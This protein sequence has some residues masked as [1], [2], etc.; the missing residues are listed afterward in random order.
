MNF[1]KMKVSSRLGLGFG[2]V[3]L[4]L[5]IVAA[6][7]LVRLSG[8]N[9][10]VEKLALERVPKLITVQAWSESLLQTSRLMREVLILDDEKQIRQAI[11]QSRE[12]MVKRQ[13]AYEN[14][15]KQAISA[16]EKELFAVITA[17]SAAYAQPEEAFLQQA[18]KA[19]FSTAK[20]ILLER[21]RPAQ[22]KYIDALRQFS[23]YHIEMSNLEASSTNA[24]YQ[25]TGSVI[26]GL[27]IFAVLSAVLAA[28]LVIRNLT[29]QLGGEPMYVAQVVGSIAA[30]NLMTEV[31]LV[32]GDD[33][34]LL[35]GISHMQESLRNTVLQIKDSS[36]TISR[37]THE[38]AQGNGDLSG[39]TEQQASSL[40]QTASSMVQL[41][42]TVKQN[43]D[44]AQQANQLAE[45]A[46]KVAQQ[47]GAV[48]AQV[49][50]TMGAINESSRKIVDIISV[51]DGIAFQTNILAL[52]AA[53]EA[54]RAGEQGRGFAVVATEVR[55]LAQRSANAAREIKA[56]ISHSVEQVG[57]GARLVDQ[58]GATMAEI[59]DSVRQVS[60][61]INDI[62]HASR[63]QTTGIEQINQAITQMDD[64]TQ[65]NAALVE[66]A[67]GAAMALQG[68]ADS[69][70]QV[71]SLFRIENG[72]DSIGS[73]HL[74]LA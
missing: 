25:T 55:N 13:A 73:R 37:A 64:V 32:R 14:L 43:A 66:Q 29:R 35:A 62:S 60:A 27:S 70:G 3:V 45:S 63:E 71:V 59:V 17:A 10:A 26:L 4:M 42:G 7:S 56:L 41:T 61:I 53:V 23:Q 6:T 1:S 11:V 20:D 74:L 22:I 16:R 57:V 19:D 39:R 54:A 67:A 40:Q 18:E 48:V 12:G 50:E 2:L 44:N 52:N 33:H 8:F 38:I 47:G 36:A 46:Q 9:G 72:R 49:V 31:T 51:I 69:L 24:A 15:Q 21:T 58:A 34:S 30:G 5:M 65:Q 68:Q 28:L